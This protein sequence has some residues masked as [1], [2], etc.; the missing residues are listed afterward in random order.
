[1]QKM[2]YFNIAFYHD[3]I[4]L[5]EGKIV[6]PQRRYNAMHSTNCERTESD[7]YVIATIILRRLHAS[8]RHAFWQ[9]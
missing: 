4:A 1:M 3:A 8:F 9:T 6:G 7:F 5:L 2:Q